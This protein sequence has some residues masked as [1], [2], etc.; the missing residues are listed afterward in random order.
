MANAQIKHITL[1]SGTTYDFVDEGARKLID[2]LASYSDYL[3]V[4]TT[5]LSDGAEIATIEIDGKSV[6]PKKGSIANYGKAEFIFNGTVWQEFGDLSALKALAYKA[7]AKGSVTAKGTVS[8]P[9]F[10]GKAVDFTPEGTVSIGT[11]TPAGSVSKPTF[12]GTSGTVTVSGSATITKGTGTANYTPEGTVSAPTVTVTPKTASVTGISS[13]GSLPSCTLPN[14]TA[15]VTDETLT[16]GWSVGSFSA[17]SLPTKATAQ[18]FMTGATV[19]ATA[20]TFTGIGAELTASVSASGSYTPT[21]TISQ[22]TF[23]G[24]GTTPTGTFIGT[25]GSVTASGTVSKP[26][27][28]GT[29]VDVTVS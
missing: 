3:G 8:Q 22:P 29:S 23:T 21:G 2:D 24:T 6:T 15:T 1:P 26:S 27:F 13:V 25:K 11:I 16:L 28:T 12:T 7:S 20:P 19:S 4:T 18:T 17:G 5:A 9:T 14:M 10:T